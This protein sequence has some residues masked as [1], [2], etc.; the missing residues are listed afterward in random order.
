MIASDELPRSL[1]LESQTKND[2]EFDT[3]DSKE[4]II[5]IPNEQRI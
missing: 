2:L 1:S 5:A 4:H 3:P